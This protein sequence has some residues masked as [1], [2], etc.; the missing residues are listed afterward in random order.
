MTAMVATV[1]SLEMLRKTRPWVR[2]ISI[3]MFIGSGLILSIGVVIFA[4]A[5]AGRGGI[6]WEQVIV[7]I[8]Y[9]PMAILQMVPAIYLSQYASRITRVLTTR[10][11]ADLEAALRAQKSFWKYIG[12]VTMVMVFLY[13]VAVAVMV[14][15]GIGAAMHVMRRP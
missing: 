15:I 13:C 14:M 12:I 7:G 10:E 6:G 5:A 9:V 2:F 11:P 8:F 4:L 3:M 1:E